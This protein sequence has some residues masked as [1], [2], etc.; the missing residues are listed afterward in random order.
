MAR[1]VL[2]SE[3]HGETFREMVAWQLAFDLN[4]RVQK[5]LQSGPAVKD[6]KFRDQL[7]DS[8]RSAPRNIAAVNSVLNIRPEPSS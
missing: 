3:V 1:H 6:F 8:A 5:L 7:A 2:T 4:E